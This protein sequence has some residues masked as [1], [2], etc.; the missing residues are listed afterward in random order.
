MSLRLRLTLRLL[1]LA[2][3]ALTLYGCDE[4]K[5]TETNST[6]FAG[7]GQDADGFRHAEPNQPLSFPQE[8]AAHPDYRIE[9][10]YLTAN[11]ED[12]AGEPVVDALSPGVDATQRTP[13][14]DALGSRSTV[15]GP[16]GDLPRRAASGGRTF[17]AQPLTGSIEHSP[18]QPSRRND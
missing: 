4:E 7:L 3:V 9:W 1:L 18:G 12:T 16:Y 10:W 14:T 6:G 2:T 5:Q 11:L 15:D 17:R 8:H 13:C